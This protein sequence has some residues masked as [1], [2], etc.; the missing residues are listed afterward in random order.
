MI[1]TGLIARVGLLLL[2]T[3]AKARHGVSRMK[4]SRIALASML[5]IAFFLFQISRWPMQQHFYPTDE[6]APRGWSIHA[7]V[8]HHYFLGYRDVPRL[9]LWNAFPHIK[10]ELEKHGFSDGVRSGATVLIVPHQGH[11]DWRK[12]RLS[13][14]QRINRLWGMLHLSKKGALQ[15]TL[16]AHFGP[17]GCPFTPTTRN[18]A[19]LLQHDLDGCVKLVT[20]RATWL[21]KA[22][23]HRGQGT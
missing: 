5:M 4:H 8:R 23:A 12:W 21:L 14:L 13:P 15:S 17:A 18:L 3:M 20:T 10:R 16:E 1:F 22:S 2:L 7:N 19:E 11:I 9:G 6:I